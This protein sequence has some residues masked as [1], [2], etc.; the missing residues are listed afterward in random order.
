MS[1]PIN[2]FPG[3]RPNN[4]RPEYVVVANQAAKRFAK[5]ALKEPMSKSVNRLKQIL[6][7][8]KSQPKKEEL[9]SVLNANNVLS[10]G[11][12]TYLWNANSRTF[13]KFVDSLRFEIRFNSNNGPYS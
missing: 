5:E 2:F 6:L 10:P 9:I 8:N 12:E 7:H 11:S 4:T 13:Q 1:F 3:A